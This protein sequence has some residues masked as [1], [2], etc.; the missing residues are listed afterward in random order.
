MQHNLSR[1]GLLEFLDYLGNK[2]L[3]N[4]TS[5]AARK[6][7][8][9]KV[10]GILDADEAADV[11][12]LDLASVFARFHN[13]EPGKYTPGSLNTYKSRVKAAID[14]FVR[15]QKDPLN[16]RPSIQTS[17]RRNGEKAK[18]SGVGRSLHPETQPPRPMEAPAAAV[19]IIPIPIR[20]DLTVKIQGIPY[21]LTPAEAVKI[22]NVVKAMAISE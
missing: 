4:P 17:S 22:A 21:D 5:A 18:P 3:M 15:Y 13:L 19:S 8:A 2:G 14:D 16:F 9:N 12:K 1:E 11:S 7:S 20:P 6:A 10:L